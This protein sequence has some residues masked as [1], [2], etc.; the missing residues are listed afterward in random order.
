MPTFVIGCVVAVLIAA[1]ALLTFMLAEQKQMNAELQELAE[2]DKL[3]MEDQYR[4]FDI[5]YGELQKQLR[6]DSLIAQIEVERRHTQQ[7]L[8]ELKN[9]KATNAAEITRLK[10]E[11]ASLRKVLKHYIMQVDSLNKLNQT[12]VSENTKIKERYRAART[13]INAI[14][15]ERN[16]LKDKVSL[17]AQLDATGFWV[18]PKNKRGRETEKV[19]NVKNIAFGFNITKN[20]TAENG[21]RIVYARI[22]KPDNSLLSKSEGTFVYENTNLEYSVKKYIEYTGEEQE[23]TLYWDVDEYLEAGTYRIF[24]FVDS[25][26]IGETSF[27]LK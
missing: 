26:M 25:Q 3:E 22:L 19:K 6:N 27:A 21:Q 12:L 14:E 20:V 11:I 24:I 1:A 16:E 4:E 10:K 17:A 18:T 23:V 13:E 15:N 2:L 7:L 5:Q 9:T 8:E